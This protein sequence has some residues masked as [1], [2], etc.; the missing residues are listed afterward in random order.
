MISHPQIIRYAN[1][2][3]QYLTLSYGSTKQ[4]AKT[5]QFTWARNPY[6][7]HFYSSGGEIWQ[8]LKDVAE[9]YDLTKYM[10]LKHQITGAYWDDDSGLWEVHIEDLQS[11]ARFTDHAEILINGS[12]LLK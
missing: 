10:K 11:G 7:S 3:C 4:H 8:Y 6:W 12:G 5:G 9:Q 2:S 1:N